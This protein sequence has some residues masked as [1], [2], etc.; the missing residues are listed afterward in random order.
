MPL[1]WVFVTYQFFLIGLGVSK[2]MVGVLSGVS[3]AWTIKF[4]WSPLV[5]RF[6]LAW[7]GRRRSW[8]IAMQLALAGTFGA[9]AA[10]AWKVAGTTTGLPQAGLVLAG[11]LGFL[12]AFF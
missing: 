8:V 2:P 4:L 6:A 10:F 3:V 12:V 1:G 5:D 7:P 9:L 11:A